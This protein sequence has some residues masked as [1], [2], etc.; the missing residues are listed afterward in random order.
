MASLSSSFNERTAYWSRDRLKVLEH[1]F[2]CLINPDINTPAI[3]EELVR[4]IHDYPKIAP[5]T[6]VNHRYFHE[7]V[8]GL[9]RIM[10]LH[11][12]QMPRVAGNAAYILGAIIDCEEG[13]SIIFQLLGDP[14]RLPDTQHCLPNLGALFA[15]PHPG[16]G[17]YDPLHYDLEAATNASG[18]TSLIFESEAGQKWAISQKASLNWMIFQMAR[19]L[20]HEDMW[21][22]SN[23]AL[24]LARLCMS[25]DGRNAILEDKNSEFTIVQLINSLGTDKQGRGMNAAFALAHLCD[26]EEGVNKV[27][28]LN[29]CLD[30]NLG[31][32]EMLRDTDEGGRKN[33]CFCLK[34]MTSHDS[35]KQRIIDDPDV[36]HLLKQL[37][38]HLTGEDEELSRMASVV[39]KNLAANTKGYLI[40]KDCSLVKSTLEQVLNEMLISEEYREDATAA[41]KEV[42]LPRPNA[43][44]LKC[45]DA[46]S[47]IAKWDAIEAKSGEI[48]NYELYKGADVVYTGPKTS[49]TVRGL[50][51]KTEYEFD[52]R[53]YTHENEESLHSDKNTVTTMKQTSSPPRNIHAV[54]VTATSIKIRWDPPAKLYGEL[55]GYILD[56]PDE[57]IHYEP[58]CQHHSAS[59]LESNK[60]YSFN[61]CAVT[62]KGRGE[63][64][65][66]TVRTLRPDLIAPSKPQLMAIS[67]FDIV[68]TWEAP[69]SPQGKINQYEVMCNGKMIYMGLNKRCVASMLTPSTK[70]RFTI[71][72]WTNNGRS[73]S[74]PSFKTTPSIKAKKKGKKPPASPWQN[75]E[76]LIEWADNTE[77]FDLAN[78]EDNDEPTDEGGDDKDRNSP[79]KTPQSSPRK[80]PTPSSS[81]RKE[82]TPNTTPR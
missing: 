1:H 49:F 26:V 37:C 15:P 6:I 80:D 19:A 20:H 58:V 57:G 59:N 21:V 41:Q 72:A 8:Y 42:L 64:A 50:T 29:E 82:A 76:E 68:A 47:V 55:K 51:E 66:I 28:N 25:E 46:N 70:Y 60:E 17:T 52:V 2:R 71:I 34:T 79:R 16:D 77:S 39:I 78:I 44:E 56:S 69:M 61:I 53:A 36:G 62:S 22:A 31:L 35:G 67:P 24:S 14:Q 9:L 7:I 27:T 40:I 10:D 3:L 74:A 43:P 4:D 73:E 63:I 30:L 81:P 18:T 54:S 13:Q 75:R 32:M 12:P 33:S 65:A 5:H 38:D 11:T 45:I 23:C 48:V